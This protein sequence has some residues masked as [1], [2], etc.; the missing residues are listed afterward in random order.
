MQLVLSYKRGIQQANRL[1]GLLRL[2]KSYLTFE[3]VYI[4][5]F[6]R[7]KLTNGENYLISVLYIFTTPKLPIY[8][9]KHEKQYLTG[10]TLFPSMF[11]EIQVVHVG[12]YDSIKQ[13]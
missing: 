7:K 2:Q 6:F 5:T 1:T 8:P 11:T 3:C 13:E 4:C 9:T 10:D 12:V